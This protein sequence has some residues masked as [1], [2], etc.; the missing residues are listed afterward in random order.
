M[1]Y[2]EATVGA[3]ILNPEDK[4]LICKS[5]KWNQQYVIPGGHIEAGESMEEALVREVK[6]ETGLDVFGL[7]LLGINESIFSDSFQ[8]QKHFIFV[9]FICHS[10]SEQ[11]VLN[12]EAQSYEWIDLDEVED[13]NLEKFTAKLLKELKKGKKSKYKKEVI[14]GI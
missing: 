4:V 14:Y 10:N 9:D 6:E 3:V 11:V 12:E 13:Y 1:R 2:P 7:E 5:N 8:N